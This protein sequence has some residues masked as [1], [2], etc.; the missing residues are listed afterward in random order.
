MNS[1]DPADLRRVYGA[2]PTGVTAIAALVAV[3]QRRNPVEG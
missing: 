3:G 1:V 2:F